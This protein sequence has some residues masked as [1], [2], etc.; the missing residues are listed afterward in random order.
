MASRL[1]HPEAL[2]LLILLIPL[3]IMF[4]V[5][6]TGRK[7]AI[8][9]MG[10]PSLV[11]R[12]M[13]SQP[14]WKHQIK[15]F[16]VLSG[17]IFLVI[18]LANPQM[19]ETP[20]KIKREGVDL[21][22][23]LDISKSMMA[24]DEKPSRLEK[25]QQFI[26]RLIDKL[27]GDRVGMI[28]FAGNAYLQVPLT[29]DYRAAKSLLKTVSTELAPT[30]GTAIG[31]AIRLAS[32]SFPAGQTQYKTMLIISDGENHEGDALEAAKKAASEGMVIHTMGIGSTRGAPIPERKNGVEDYKRDNSGAIVF[33]KLNPEM[34]REVAEAGNGRYFT[35]SQGTT[36]VK[37]FMDELAAMEKKEFED[38]E[39]TD[40]EDYFQ[41]FLAAGLL[42][43]LIEYFITESRSR[44]FSDWR[45]FRES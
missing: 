1:E 29:S 3:A 9:R 15:F 37:A 36:E 43:L 11:A 38:Q 42:L 25:S 17:L 8:R 4:I 24:E 31:E 6:W 33:S 41:L 12:L 20:R 10:E 16:L 2:Y 30:Q 44:I 45:I 28:V 39:F 34:L 32:E 26:S 23:A 18:A 27:A 14:T 13:P 7:R 5:F 40:Y 35:L 19:S 22:I 21:I